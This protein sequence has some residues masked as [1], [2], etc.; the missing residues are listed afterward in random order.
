MEGGWGFSERLASELEV[1]ARCGK[2]YSCGVGN[3]YFPVDP[4]V[5][6]F[7]IQ[8]VQC[9]TRTCTREGRMK[10]RRE[11]KGECGNERKKD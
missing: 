1:I 6:S 9:S 2:L 7:S 3:R 10:H 8:V 4:S 5:E 11:P